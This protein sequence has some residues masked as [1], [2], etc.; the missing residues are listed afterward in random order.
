MFIAFY[1]AWSIGAN[2]E[3]GAPLAGRGALS[4]NIEGFMEVVRRQAKRLVLFYEFKHHDLG[5][6]T[7]EEAQERH[8]SYLSTRCL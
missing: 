4:L 7:A 6:Y 2:D 3:T 1:V 8:G 5:G